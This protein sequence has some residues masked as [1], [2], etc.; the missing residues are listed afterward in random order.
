MK[1]NIVEDGIIY[2]CPSL[3]ECR[4]IWAINAIQSEPVF[5]FHCTNCVGYKCYMLGYTDALNEKDANN[6]KNN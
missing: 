6:E 4:R 1:K 3:E 5:L 2:D